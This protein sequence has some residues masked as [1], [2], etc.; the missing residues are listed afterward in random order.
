[1]TAI[2]HSEWLLQDIAANVTFSFVLVNQPKNLVFY[3]VKVLNIGCY[4]DLPFLV[5][6]LVLQE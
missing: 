4:L 5:L 3:V 1:M 2:E 6:Y